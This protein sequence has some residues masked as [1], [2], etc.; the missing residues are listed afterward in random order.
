MYKRQLRVLTFGQRDLGSAS[1]FF[2]GEGEGLMAAR[3]QC[4][5][6]IVVVS[7]SIM[8]IDEIFFLSPLREGEFVLSRQKR[9]WSVSLRRTNVRNK[10]DSLLFFF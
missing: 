10:E 7:S 3:F 4:T 8:S 5:S 9:N 2:W 6:S 1:L